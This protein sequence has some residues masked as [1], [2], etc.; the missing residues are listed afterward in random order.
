MITVEQGPLS[1]RAPTNRKV[2]RRD[3]VPFRNRRN[4]LSPLCRITGGTGGQPIK[5]WDL[6]D[7]ASHAVCHS[8][9]ERPRA[10]VSS[11]FSSLVA[12]VSAAT[13][14]AYGR[15]VPLILIPLLSPRQ[16]QA[17]Q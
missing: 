6:L 7:V 14:S 11:R 15:S 9:S 1:R 16:R 12:P 8:L 17:S 10:A 13:R 2:S 3:R 5:L 4:S